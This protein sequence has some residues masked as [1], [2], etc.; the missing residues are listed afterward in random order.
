MDHDP[1]ARHGL[2]LIELL[3]VISIIALLVS[4]LL[5]ALGNARDA[6]RQISCAT[7]FRQIMVGQSAFAVDYDAMLSRLAQVWDT[8]TVW[9]ETWNIS[10]TATERQAI[11]N[12]FTGHGMLVD[13]GYM[14]EP[15]LLYCPAHEWPRWQFQASEA[16]WHQSGFR[17]T[18][19][20]WQGVQQRTDIKS[21]NEITESPSGVSYTSDIFTKFAIGKANVLY[22]H[23][24]GFNVAYLDGSTVYY[25]AT[26]AV[27]D[28]PLMVGYT[29]G[30]SVVDGAFAAHFDR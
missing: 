25:N 23:K 11:I 27:E 9:R 4:L 7:Q 17:T 22:H 15:R 16:D 24:T 5:P 6:A 14:P 12:K 3:V 28:E 29:A 26:A 21:L 1:T 8:Q 10:P 18:I 30:R 19:H 20:I 2:T 13:Q